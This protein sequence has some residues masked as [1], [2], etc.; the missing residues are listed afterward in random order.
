MANTARTSTSGTW[1]HWVLGGV[2]VG[3]AAWGWV[4]APRTAQSQGTVPQA[5][6]ENLQVFSSTLPNGGQQIVV[7]EPVTQTMAVYHIAGAEGR[8]Q[9]KSVRR[10]AWDLRMEQFNGEPPSPSEIRAVQP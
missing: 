9:L 7:I 6:G 3:I 1:R 2:L 10:I 4:P 8:I 5:S